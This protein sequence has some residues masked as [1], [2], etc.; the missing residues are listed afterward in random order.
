ML[1]RATIR[2]LYPRAEDAHLLA[3]ANQA[4]AL[5]RRFQIDANS[6][7]LHYFLAQIGHESGGLTIMA[8]NLNYRAERLVAVWPKRFPTV[9]SARPLAGNP[10]GLA[11]KVYA[12]RMGNGPESSG[13]G[14]RYHGRG[15]IQLTG[16]DGYQQVGKLAGLDL[17]GHPDLAIAPDHAL[18][19]ACAFW[20]WKG[21][22][23]HCDTGDFVKVTQ[24]INGGTNG[25]IDRRAWLDK[26]RRTLANPPSLADM[27]AP[28]TAIALQR[29]LQAKGYKEIGAA[30]GIVGPRTI[31][32]ITRFR[33][34]E[35]LGEGLID[36]ALKEALGLLA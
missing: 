29:A 30:D 7:R 16:R 23:A 3:F 27:P 20:Q 14:W 1:T 5:F 36:D 2:E 34:K 13:D 21:L 4:E 19:V 9:D 25:L 6:L 17:T 35:K 10:Q 26:V 15:Y 8:E 28:E 32:A 22:N 24:V 33:Q 12:K 18:L 11:N 31:A